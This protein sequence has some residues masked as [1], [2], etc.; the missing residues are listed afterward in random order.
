MFNWE[1]CPIGLFDMYMEV[2]EV[3][4]VETPENAVCIEVWFRDKYTGGTPPVRRP[5]YGIMKQIL[6][7][8]GDRQAIL[9]FMCEDP[10]SRYCIDAESWSSAIYLLL[11]ELH[12]LGKVRASALF[13]HKSPAQIQQRREGFFRTDRDREEYLAL[14]DILDV[15]VACQPNRYAPAD[16]RQI[17]GTCP[18]DLAA[19]LS[20]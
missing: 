12:C 7:L 16:N 11:R 19:F 15:L 4:A 20:P 8:C 9:L 5:I 10:V 14:Y 18:E 6:K 3:K 17:I 1:G 13:T 2:L